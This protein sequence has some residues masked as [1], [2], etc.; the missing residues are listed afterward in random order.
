MVATSNIAG[1]RYREAGD[2]PSLHGATSDLAVDLDPKVIREFATTAAR[3]TA[4][5]AAIAGTTPYTTPQKGMR[6]YVTAGS[7]G[8]YG[9]WCGWN[10]TEWIWD[11]PVPVTYNSGLVGGPVSSTTTAFQGVNSSPHTVTPSRSGMAII[12]IFVAASSGATGYGT[13]YL[14]IRYSDG[15]LLPGNTGFTVI[16]NAPN[17]TRSDRLHEYPVPIYL[18]KNV[19]ITLA[20]DIWS[21]T[22]G[23]PFWQLVAHQWYVTQI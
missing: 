22:Q 9:D 1:L 17:G 8:G 13:G 6:C 11:N 2:Q 14:K 21:N 12:R 23:G 10:G 15:S 18:K 7:G 4:Y 19:A 5:T 20:F 3:D 16:E